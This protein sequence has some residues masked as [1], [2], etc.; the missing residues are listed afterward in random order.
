MWL[1]D[2]IYHLVKDLLDI[3]DLLRQLMLLLHPVNFGNK[4]AVLVVWPQ[5]SDLGLNLRYDLLAVVAFVT[6]DP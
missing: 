5:R 6:G 2:C 3:A 4:L 1:S